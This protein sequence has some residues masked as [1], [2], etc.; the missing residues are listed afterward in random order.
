M[1]FFGVASLIGCYFS[2][3]IVDVRLHRGDAR[4]GVSRWESALP[5]RGLK[6]SDC[7]DTVGAP[8]WLCFL[9]PLRRWAALEALCYEQIVGLRVAKFIRY[10]LVP[11]FF[12]AIFVARSEWIDLGGDR[13]PQAQSQHWFLSEGSRRRLC[14]DNFALD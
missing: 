13:I 12:Y 10:Y 11:V 14:T 3:V 9:W 6:R 8:S 7:D 4:K 5:M 1:P 2:I